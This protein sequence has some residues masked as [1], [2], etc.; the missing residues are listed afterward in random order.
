MFM[1]VIY[2]YV[3]VYVDFYANNLC[4]YLSLSLSMYKYMIMNMSVCVNV[5]WLFLCLYTVVYMSSFMTNIQIYPQHKRIQE[6]E[7]KHSLVQYF[8]IVLTL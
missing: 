5:Y 7:H 8:I 4:L 2:V 3:Y 6:I 1:F